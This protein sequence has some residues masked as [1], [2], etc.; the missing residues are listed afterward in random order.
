LKNIVGIVRTK[1]RV[2]TEKEKELIALEYFRKKI[3]ENSLDCF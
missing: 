1:E 3:Q 2:L